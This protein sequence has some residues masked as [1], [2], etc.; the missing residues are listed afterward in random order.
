MCTHTR[1]QTVLHAARGTV[2]DFKD[3]KLVIEWDP[4]YFMDEEKLEKAK[5]SL[6][7]VFDF[8]MAEDVAQGRADAESA[9]APAVAPAASAVAPAATAVAPAATEVKPATTA[10]AKAGSATKRK[11]SDLDSLQVPEMLAAREFTLD[12]V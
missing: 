7:Q 9:D 1:S 5:A 4:I 8:K 6:V 11:P 10:K 3:N 12:I 2:A